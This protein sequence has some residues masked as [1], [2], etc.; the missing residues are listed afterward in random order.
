MS[1]KFMIFLKGHSFC[2]LHEPN[3]WMHLDQWNATVIKKSVIVKVAYSFIP[4]LRFSCEKHFADCVPGNQTT[5]YN[6]TEAQLVFKF[7]F[8]LVVHSLCHSSLFLPLFE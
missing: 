8:W 3:N 4:S 2:K 1:K 7:P 5:F 6:V